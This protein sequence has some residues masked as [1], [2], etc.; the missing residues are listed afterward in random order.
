MLLTDIVSLRPISLRHAGID[1]RLPECLAAPFDCAHTDMAPLAGDSLPERII[2]RGIEL[3]NRAVTDSTVTAGSGG[4]SVGR[5]ETGCAPK[6]SPAVRGE[7][8]RHHAG[9][10]RET[11]R[12]AAR[13]KAAERGRPLLHLQ[14]RARAQ[15]IARS[16]PSS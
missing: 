16:G 6:G 11:G 12:E 10:D 9:G 3:V 15:I 4:G 2:Q 5:V 8:R 13:W 14:D 1:Q 7:P